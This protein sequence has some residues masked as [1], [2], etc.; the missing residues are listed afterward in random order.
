MVVALALLAV[1]CGSGS[2]SQDATHPRP[3]PSA[4]AAPATTTLVSDPSQLTAPSDAVGVVKV[5]ARVE[6]ALRDSNRDPASS[7]ALGWEQQLAYGAL[8]AHPEWLAEVLAALPPEIAAVVG[9]NRAAGAAL[10]SPGLGAPPTELPDWTILTPRPPDVLLG[11]YREAEVSSGIPWAYLAAIHFVE[12][13]MGRIHGNSP[14]GAQ[15]PMQFVPSTWADYG[16]GEDI[17]DD[18]AAILAAGRYL[19]AAGGP[20]D[21]DAALF[22]YNHSSSYVDAIKLYAGVMLQSP[23]AYYGY[24]SWQVYVQTTDGV[25]RLPEGWQRPGGSPGDSPAD[26]RRD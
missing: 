21:M 9:A 24:Y 18:R 16:E 11:Y 20:A 3:R 25:T 7:P 12:T 19:R 15:G 6:P 8:L 4:S 17:N 1:G 13:R 2:G 26:S 23:R 5:L 10:T 14:A 22:A